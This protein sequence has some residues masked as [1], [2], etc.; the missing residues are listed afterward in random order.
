MLIQMIAATFS[1]DR[2]VVLMWHLEKLVV[3]RLLWI[4]LQKKN[5]PNIFQFYE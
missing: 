3:V 1:Q 4:Q 2:D 5:V